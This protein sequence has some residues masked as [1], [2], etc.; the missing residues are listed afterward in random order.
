M[1]SRNAV[2]NANKAGSRSANIS[3]NEQSEFTLS[4]NVIKGHLTPHNIWS[5]L[6]EMS[7]NSK[8]V[9]GSGILGCLKD[10][11]IFRAMPLFV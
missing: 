10:I 8:Y 2:F 6:G 11:V 7:S 4:Q 3:F 1:L 9:M 5:S